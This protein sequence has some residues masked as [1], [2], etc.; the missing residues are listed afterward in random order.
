M[1]HSPGEAA[2][3]PSAGAC[4]RE[5]GEAAPRRR[6][7]GPGSV[8]GSR[9]KYRKMAHAYAHWVGALCQWLAGSSC[10]PAGGRSTTV[11]FSSQPVTQGV[12]CITV[13]SGM[14]TL[15]HSSRGKP[16]KYA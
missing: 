15:M 14:E 9:G 5:E 11:R 1:L 7:G 4:E 3:P 12:S 8:Y 13:L 6:L 2:P 10:S 16:M